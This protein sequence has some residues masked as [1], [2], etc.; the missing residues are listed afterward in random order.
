MRKLGQSRHGKSRCITRLWLGA[1]EEH[2]HHWHGRHACGVPRA[3][4]LVEGWSHCR[5]FCCKGADTQAGRSGQCGSSETRSCCKFIT[6]PRAGPVPDRRA[7]TEGPAT[8]SLR[9]CLSSSCPGR[10]RQGA[11]C[12][13]RR[14][15]I[16][17]ATW[18]TTSS[19][20]PS[21]PELEQG[22]PPRQGRSGPGRA[23]Q[24]LLHSHHGARVS[25][26]RA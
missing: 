26:K 25:A 13:G 14:T 1:K 16:S 20:T 22:T 2:A 3:G 17:L 18:G 15:G 10:G 19:S 7:P 4:V 5:T 12:S 8:G 9:F 23:C 11:A 21:P 6:N 24:W